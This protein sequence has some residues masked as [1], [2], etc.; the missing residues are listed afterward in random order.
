LEVINYKY[1]NKLTI[2]LILY[3]GMLQNKHEKAIFS[4]GDLTH[5]ASFTKFQN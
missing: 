4:F 2:I 3:F 5:D 1:Y